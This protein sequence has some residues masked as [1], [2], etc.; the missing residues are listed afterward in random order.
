MGF[1][2]FT[3]RSSDDGA[4]S[5]QGQTTQRLRSN[6]IVSPYPMPGSPR[7]GK[8]VIKQR[9]GFFGTI[10]LLI[11]ICV[12]AALGFGVCY[13]LFHFDV[14]GIPE[15]PVLTEEKQTITVEDLES[16]IEPA[17]DLITLRYRYTEADIVRNA[18]EF[19][20]FELPLTEE[21][22]IIRY[23]G[24]VGAGIDISK[25]SFN[26]Q[27]SEDEN[28]KGRI[29]VTLPKLKVVQNEIDEESFEV[30]TVKQTI[31]NPQGI[32]DATQLLAELKKKA[33]KR[34]L[35]DKQFLAD[36]RTNAET[37]LSNFLTGANVGAYY[38]IELTWEEEA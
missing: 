5:D 12:V 24:I 29:V 2:W 22:E 25:V 4:Q 32:S 37:V 27:D 8:Y 16:V 9:R 6:P 30:V 15:P 28:G 19:M 31:F 17:S 1:G 3:R 11:E 13:A 20:D 33:K 35:E 7:T 34:V 38:D 14:L 21:V 26:V 18:K 10:W 36:A 23:S